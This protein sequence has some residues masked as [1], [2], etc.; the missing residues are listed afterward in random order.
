MSINDRRS[1]DE[2][3]GT[4]VLSYQPNNDLLLY[5]SYSRGYKAG[6]FNLDRSALKSPIFPFANTP[7]GGPGAGRQ[8]AVRSGDQHRLRSRRQIFARPDHPQ[9]R[10][11]RQD[12]RNFQLNTFNGTVFLVQTSTAATISSAAAWRPDQSA[13]PPVELQRRRAATGACAPGDVSYGV[14]SQGIE[15]EAPDPAAARHVAQSRPDPR[16]HEIPRQSGRQR[17][18]RAARSG[19]SRA[20][21]RTACPT[22]RGWCS[23]A[24]SPGRRRSATPA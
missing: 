3:T 6:G 24:R 15:V 11:F 7:G 5:A 10:R 12:F 14:R 21:G 2:W 13:P 9:R 18:R 20:A 4:G 22:R 16:Q 23:P 8:S 1:E 19:A 17:E